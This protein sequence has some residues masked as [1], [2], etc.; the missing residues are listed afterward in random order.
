MIRKLFILILAFALSIIVTTCKKNTEPQKFT[1]AQIEQ[2]YQQIKPNADAALLS[3]NPITEFEKLAKELKQMEEIKQVTTS[4]R[5][6]IVEFENGEIA[7]WLIAFVPDIDLVDFKQSHA[8]TKVNHSTKNSKPK[9]CLINQVY[10]DERFEYVHDLFYVIKGSFIDENWDV[11]VVNGEQ[12]NLNFT[13]SRLNDFDVVDIVTHGINTSWWELG[14]TGTF[15]LI[16]E[17]QNGKKEYTITVTLPEMRNNKMVTVEY[18]AISSE[19]ITAHYANNSFNNSLIY[20]VACEGLKKPEHFGKAFVDKGVKVVVGW[21]E[22]NCIGAVTSKYLLYNLLNINNLSEAINLLQEEYKVDK[23]SNHPEARLTFYPYPTG[24]TYKLPIGTDPSSLKITDPKYGDVYHCGMPV[25]I[26]VSGYTGSDWKDNL[27]VIVACL[28]G[29]PQHT[30][31]DEPNVYKGNAL[32]RTE[33]NYSFTFTPQT[34]STWAGRWVKIIAHNKKNNTWSAPQYIKI[35]PIDNEDGVV[36]NGICWATR[37]VDMPGTFA[38]K[39]E[40]A[41]MFYQWN[42]KIGWSNTNPLINSNGDST[43]DSSLPSGTTWEKSNDPCPTGWRVP[44]KDELQ[45]LENTISTWT[46]M[47]DVNGRIFGSG[48]NTIFLP[49]PGSRSS[50]GTLYDVGSYAYY[51]GNSLNIPT[52]AVDM[53]FTTSHT[54]MGSHKCMLGQSVRCVAE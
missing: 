16:G 2:A 41:G 4:E 12:F 50:Y 51:W 40:D 47:N 37:N 27:E 22:T 24:G 21:D 48:N 23:H 26:F 1:D 5:G 11:T 19:F 35:A 31:N 44:T 54:F 6:L 38:A 36:I 39:P 13:Q 42:R 53:W 45:N 7:V 9:I 20:L 17:K 8:P 29:E 34:P 32:P 30:N 18:Y 49:A 15:I 52:Y 43:W 25:D 46:S 14:T 10:Y 28:V 3:D 33:A